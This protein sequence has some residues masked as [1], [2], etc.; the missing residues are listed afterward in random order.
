MCLS[1]WRVCLLPFCF[2]IAGLNSN[3]I[4]LV[5]MKIINNLIQ[6]VPGQEGES[7]SV[8]SNVVKP[9]NLS[10]FNF[11]IYKFL[12]M[13]FDKKNLNFKYVKWCTG[14]HI[15]IWW[16][17][18]DIAVSHVWFFYFFILFFNFLIFIMETSLFNKIMKWD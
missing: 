12:V 7:V 10:S 8:T 3:I 4:N 1:I 2:I 6:C 9:G 17:F 18:S 14:K 16:V 11:E 15:S 13:S 5:A